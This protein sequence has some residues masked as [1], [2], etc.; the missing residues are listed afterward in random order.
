MLDGSKICVLVSQLGYGGAE[1][2]TTVLLE[3][4]S[5]QYG[6]RPL[7]CCMSPILE[8]FGRRI[9]EA[10]CQL[11]HWRRE[12]SYE[13]RRVFYLRRLLVARGIRLL[14]AVHYQAAAYA[15][16]A[17][18]GLRDLALVPSVRST[19]Y[20][21]SLRKRAFYRLML[22][23]SKVIIS[24]SITGGKWLE[25]FYGVQADHV[26]VVPNGLDPDL[27][28]ATPARRRVRE[29]LTIPTEAPLVAFVGKTNSHKGLPSLV[30]VFRRVLAARPEAHL[31]V[32]GHGLTPDWVR[33]E[34]GR[35][36]ASTAW[37]PATTSTI[38][39]A[40]RMPCS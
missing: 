40:P 27:L 12:K 16:L 28:E 37:E 5:S 20:D 19:V 35:S 36:P 24:N 13:L 33:E 7:V 17:R 38:S 15:W 23:R 3:E 14:H 30:R 39:S 31:I 22:P 25:Q 21:P 29:K 18:L 2:Q 11:V 6:L 26:T 1:R 10:G 4:L 34:F 32:M 8:P 9:R